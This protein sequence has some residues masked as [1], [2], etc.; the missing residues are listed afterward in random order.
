MLYPLNFVFWK[1]VSLFL[2]TINFINFDV[3]AS[4]AIESENQ[5]QNPSALI[6]RLTQAID[7]ESIEEMRCIKPE[8]EILLKQDLDPAI[9]ITVMSAL[10]LVTFLLEDEVQGREMINQSMKIFEESH[11]LDQA[12]M[13]RPW[14]YLGIMNEHQNNYGQAVASFTECFFLQQNCFSEDLVYQASVQLHLGKVYQKLCNYHMAFEFVQQS[15]DTYQKL[16]GQEDAKT[17]LSKLNIAI[18]HENS[19]NYEEAQK[20]LSEC[21]DFYQKNKQTMGGKYAWTKLHLA[22]V[23]HKLGFQEKAQSLYEEAVEIYKNIY[24]E[25]GITVAWSSVHLGD[26]YRDI[27]E[28]EKLNKLSKRAY[29]FIKK[30]IQKIT[31]VWPGF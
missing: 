16:L 20:L 27:G 12:L 31:Y 2:L 15:H 23:N 14:F 8:G 22:H 7:K 26:F 3:F 1:K 13:M 30:F 17:Y 19:G 25:D 4:L 24:A 9:K 6:E 18:I 10:G 28:F 29:L 5:Q 11:A 21:L